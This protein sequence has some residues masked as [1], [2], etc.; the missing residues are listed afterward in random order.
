MFVRAYNA[1]DGRILWENGLDRPGF[2][3]FPWGVGLLGLAEDHGK[4]TIAGLGTLV[5][6]KYN[7]N[8]IVRTYDA[9]FN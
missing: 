5:G 1:N 6:G 9:G 4:V 8:W 2:F 7:Y 3:S